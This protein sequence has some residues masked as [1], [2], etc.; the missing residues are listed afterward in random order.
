MKIEIYET[1]FNYIN[2]VLT[3]AVGEWEQKMT[4]ADVCEA[5]RERAREYAKMARR[6]RELL[7]EAKYNSDKQ[8]KCEEK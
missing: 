2:S 6:A 5:N 8:A 3:Y 7:N 4:N 1:D